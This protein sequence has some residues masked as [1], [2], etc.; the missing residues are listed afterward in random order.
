MAAIDFN[1]GLNMRGSALSA[2]SKCHLV[3][4][5]ITIF[6]TDFYPCAVQAREKGMPIGKFGTDNVI[7][8]EK[9]FVEHDSHEDMICKKFCMDFK[10]M[11][12]DRV[13]QFQC[14]NK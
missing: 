9:W 12:N 3:R 7:L 10:C 6:G 1:A 13:E 5:D 4:D 11:F 8:R 14:E 2:T